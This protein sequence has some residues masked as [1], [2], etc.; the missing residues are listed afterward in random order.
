[1][2]S[3]SKNRKYGSNS[4]RQL[5]ISPPK[6]LLEKSEYN[7]PLY[8]YEYLNTVFKFEIDPCAQDGN[9]YLGVDYPYTS[10]DDGLMQEWNKPT[11]V[12][13]PYGEGNEFIWL[14]K[15]INEFT[16]HNKPIFI[17]LPAKT[18]L[19]WF[20]IGMLTANIIILPRGR[21]NFVKDG[22]VKKGN[23]IGSVIFGYCDIEGKEYNKFMKFNQELGPEVVQ[24]VDNGF[25]SM[26]FPI[27]K[28]I[29]E[30]YD[31]EQISGMDMGMITK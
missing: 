22:K 12:N 23:I 2:L 21:I 25:A 11:F 4:D 19:E 1:M 28:K 7:T 3:I 27:L 8:L 16:K 6:T 10:V 26:Y 17:L 31:I 30:I 18:E 14:D 13:P 15:T 29:K 20:H 24:I 9:N 5:K